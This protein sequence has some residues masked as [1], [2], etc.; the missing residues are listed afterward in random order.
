MNSELAPRGRMPSE[1]T[2]AAP[3]PNLAARP[4]IDEQRLLQAVADNSLAIVDVVL[5]DG[6][7]LLS[8]GAPLSLGREPA[9]RVGASAFEFVHPEDLP[10]YRDWLR[11]LAAVPDRGSIEDIELRVLHA[12]GGWRSYRQRGTNLL[13]D[14]DVG[15]LLEVGFDET[16]RKAAEIEAARV[17]QRLAL[18]VAGGRLGFYTYDVE[19][20]RV[21]ASA[22]C[23]RMRGYAVPATAALSVAELEA[24]IHAD[25]R[26]SVRAARTRVIGGPKDVFDIEFRARTADGD[27]LWV[28]LRGHVVQRTV[29]GAATRIVGVV[30]DVDRRKRAELALAQSEARYR[31]VIAMTP[32]FVHESA[33]GADGALHLRWASDGFARLL[34]WT[35]EEVNARGGWS[36]I[37][38]P[39]H[40]PDAIARR[41]RVLAGEP[42]ES[43]LQLL[44][45]DGDWRW[46]AATTFP[47]READ[48]GR[49]GS[50]LGMMYD[51]TSRKRTEEQLRGSEER[52]RIAAEAVD[53]VIYERDVASRQVTSS[54]GITQVLGYPDAAVTSLDWW[55][56]RIHPDDVAGFLAQRLAA[57]DGGRLV[58]SRYRLRHARGHYVD[59]LD[60]AVR[61]RDAAGRIVRLVGSV[62]DV[63]REQRVERLLREAEALAHAGSWEI[64]L[65]TG[66]LRFSDETYRVHGLSKDHGPIDLATAIGYYT[67]QSAAQVRAAIER[68]SAT[69]VGFD[70]DAE[71][72]RADG[73]HRC[74]RASGRA[75][76]VD[77]RPVRLYGALQDIDDLKRSEI[78]IRE[79]S[80]WLRLAM[81]AAALLA[82]TWR[83]DD[84]RM[85][86]KFRSSSFGSGHVLRPTLSEELAEVVAEDRAAVYRGLQH[87]VATGEPTAFDFRAVGI[88]GRPYHFTA[89]ALRAVEDGRH[90]A[91]GA[92]QDI[93]ARRAAEEQLRASEAVLRSVTENSPDLIVVTDAALR[94]TF[95]NR[96]LGGIEPGALLGQ[97]AAEH[98]SG[99]AAEILPRLRRVLATGRAER[100]ESALRRADG[101]ESVLEHRIAPIEQGGAISGLI[102]Q[103][104]EISERRALEREILEISNREQRRIGSDLHDGLGQ[105]LTGISLLLR[106]L[107]SAAARGAAPAAAELDEIVVLV[108]G[109][110]D[111]T[112]TLARGLSP[113]ALDGGGLVDALRALAARARELYGLDVRFRSRVLPRVTLDAAAAGHLY[114][115]AQESLTNAA[116]HAAAKA[117]LL[118]F[119]ARGRRVLLA[120]TD[121]GQGLPSQSTSGMGLRIMHYRAHMLGG[122]LSI[123]RGA[124]GRGTRVA[125]SLSQPD[126]AATAPAAQ[127]PRTAR[128]MR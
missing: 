16:A 84:D 53:G 63:S 82:W 121:D 62:M 80:E 61:V 99:G 81:D 71:I 120:V 45:K 118:H 8:R 44:A 128:R 83:P 24:E 108:N 23:F 29:A 31:T 87:T 110:I 56:A 54:G 32:G 19:A 75:E 30:L 112:R 76:M 91:I 37:I 103:S 4:P 127:R 9:S 39:G 42:V 104:T 109:A 86:E 64:D 50:M 15:G 90:V 96:A 79:Q 69:G 3:V 107:A 114:R 46:F 102:I 13:R 21:E 59:V 78:R 47:L 67:P 89:R 12:D 65:A 60:R 113:V 35:T 68:A 92:A 115:I 34:G 105:E 74:V 95:A 93:T 70:L 51:I 2:E 18:V 57:D 85:L 40:A 77:G 10:R 116:R 123:G 33:P 7:I 111:T 27:W 26:D 5:P 58:Y 124:N 125:C 1:A 72:V 117:V 94:V 73:V 25:E 36:A 122:E 106:S 126:P 100:H 17:S 22:E 48:S 6:T 98:L 43:E 52:F 38:H 97:P 14:P 119:S 20:D 28:N 49:V 101:S 66:E 41:A 11:R 88:E 55:I